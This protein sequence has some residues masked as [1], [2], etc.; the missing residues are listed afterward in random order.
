M[1]FLCCTLGMQTTSF[2]E[3]AKFFS[4]GTLVQCSVLELEGSKPGQKK[5]KLSLDPKEVNS[6]LSKSSLKPGMV[7]RRIK[8]IL[9]F[10][11]LIHI[12]L[13][14]NVAVYLTYSYSILLLFWVLIF[15]FSVAV[16]L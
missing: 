14:P 16:N 2:P 13:L 9:I 8:P 15:Y 4:V 12:I 1:I 11:Y 3:L 5:V 7:G 10:F 6:G